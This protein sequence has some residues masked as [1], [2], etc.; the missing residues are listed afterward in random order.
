[1]AF[2]GRGVNYM[3]GS[4]GAPGVVVYSTQED[5]RAT[6]RGA[7][8]MT[9]ASVDASTDSTK[10]ADQREQK[11]LEDGVTISRLSKEDGS[12]TDANSGIPIVI[13]AADGLAMGTLVY[14][15][16]GG[17]HVSATAAWQLNS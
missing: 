14:T 8:Y 9:K 12:R 10:A 15:A 4:S 16:G 1:M 17:L 11:S 6:V 13:N 2:R 7:A 3:P 5:S